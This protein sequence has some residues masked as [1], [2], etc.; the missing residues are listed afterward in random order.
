MVIVGQFERVR[1]ARGSF[2]LGWA[3]TLPVTGTPMAGLPVTGIFRTVHTL[4][5][6]KTGIKHSLPNVHWFHQS[7]TRLKTDISLVFTSPCD[8]EKML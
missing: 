2:S 3:H 1:P 4:P 5:A 7:F 6:V 8:S